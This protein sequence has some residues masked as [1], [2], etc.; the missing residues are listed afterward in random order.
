MW[1][2]MTDTSKDIRITLTLEL[3]SS[4]EKEGKGRNRVKMP[5]RVLWTNSYSL[6]VITFLSPRSYNS[7]KKRTCVISQCVPCVLS[8]QG[9]CLKGTT[10]EFESVDSD[11]FGCENR[12]CV[13]LSV[14]GLR[15]QREPRGHVMLW[16]R[17]VQRG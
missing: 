5:P 2:K 10:D 12:C 1:H 14:S 8:L 11:F 7:W 13:V 9:G 15:V 17:S 3:L 6:L 16:L 4:W